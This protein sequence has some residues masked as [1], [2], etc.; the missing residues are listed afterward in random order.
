MREKIKD[1]SFG[2]S[3][4]EPLWEGGPDS[5]Y[6]F[7]VDEVFVLMPWMVKPNSGRQLTREERIANYRISRVRN[8]FGEFVWNIREQ[9]QG[10]TGHHRPKVKDC[11]RHCFYICG[12]AQYAKDTPG[13]IGQ[14]NPSRRCNGPIECTGC[15]CSK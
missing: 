7:P 11:Q 14:G 2:L 3:Q 13:L 9:I 1:G 4:P 12:A 15:I 8:G 6:F 5:D 10:T